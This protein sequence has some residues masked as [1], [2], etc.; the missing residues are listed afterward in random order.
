MTRL[1]PSS[2]PVAVLN[3]RFGVAGETVLLEPLGV[4]LLEPADLCRPLANLRADTDAIWSALDYALH[5]Y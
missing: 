5:G 1:K 4:A 3:P 2:A